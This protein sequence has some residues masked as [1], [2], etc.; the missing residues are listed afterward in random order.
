MSSSTFTLHAAPLAVPGDP[1]ALERAELVRDGFSWGA[2]LAPM[3]Y[4]FWHRSWLAGLFAALAVAAL[5][6]GLWAIGAR[7]GIII[8]AEVLLHLLFGLEGSSLR[9]LALER[10]GRPVS[11]VVVAADSAEAEAKTFARWLGPVGAVEQPGPAS[12]AAPW[13]APAPFR[14]RSEPVIGLFPDAEGRR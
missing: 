5:A 2:C 11:D 7:P 10:R 1:R 6:G 4:F 9:R 3:L 12:P 14:S 13:S 8:L